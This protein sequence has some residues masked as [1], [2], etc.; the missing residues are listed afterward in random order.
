MNSHSHIESDADRPWFDWYK[1][2]NKYWDT[3]WNAYDSYT[4]IRSTSITFVF[5]TAWSA[6]AAIY[7]KL[8]DLGYDME[9]KW[10]DEDLGSNCGKAICEP[11]R[12]G[13]TDWC[14]THEEELANPRQFARNIWNKY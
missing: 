8:K 7:S 14:V 2:H 3:K 10:A 5:S 9:M 1:W 6:P 4:T 11:K 13:F 12:T